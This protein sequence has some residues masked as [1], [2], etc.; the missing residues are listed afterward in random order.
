MAKFCTECGKKLEEGKKCSCKTTV[1]KSEV[2][3]VVVVRSNNE[4]LDKVVD[5]LKFIFIKP[6]TVIKK[7][8]KSVNFNLGMVLILLTSIILA[9]FVTINIET[10]YANIY[11]GVSA[12]FRGDIN[13]FEV[14]VY[15][16][17]SGISYFALLSGIS[18]IVL[19]KMFK[20]QTNF[21]KITVFIGIISVIIALTLLTGIIGFALSE[22]IG[23]LVVYAGMLFYLVTFYHGLKSIETIGDDKCG[24]V[25]IVINVLQ[26]LSIYLLVLLFN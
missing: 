14:F 6:I 2:K 9:G 15:S 21:K 11:G 16:L 24:F 26:L 8:T 3:E 17:I 23:F 4:M 10:L 22:V 7:Y 12:F 13:E 20:I 25:F 1:K 5:I 19:D 18:Y